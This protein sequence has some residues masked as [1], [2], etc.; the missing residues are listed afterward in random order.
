M[1]CAEA[2]RRSVNKPRQSSMAVLQRKCACG[3][4]S[5]LT[6]SCFD[7]E[8][9]LIGKPLQTKL[10]ISE[11]G[12]EYEQEADRLAA[13]VMR[14]PDSDM[15]RGNSHSGSRRRLCND[16]QAKVVRA[17]NRHRHLSRKS[18]IFGTAAR[19]SDAGVF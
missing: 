18:I 4:S 6:G 11:P 19:C 5:G 12:D 15:N 8:T 16:G 10:R 7:C 3:G 13:Q 14:M 2:I 1:I 9:K 17:M